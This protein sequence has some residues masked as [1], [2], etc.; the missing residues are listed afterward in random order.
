VEELTAGLEAAGV[1]S[2]LI[3]PLARYGALV[4]D[5]NRRF[6]LTGAKTAAELLPHLIDSLTVVPYLREPYV[7]IGSGAG[8][9]AIPA[10]IASRLPVTMIEATRKKV[11]FLTEALATLD[12][13]GEAFAE[14][15]EVAGQNEQFRERFTSGTAR[16]VSSAPT[17]AEL[18]LPLIAPGGIAVLQRGTIEPRE[19]VALDDACLILGAEVEEEHQLEGER[20]IIVIRKRSSTPLRFPRRTGIP[21][22][23]PLCFQ[24]LG[25][26]F[27]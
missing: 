19:R 26:E 22:K 3:D 11:T 27:S 15:A 5:A 9:P 7:D 16:A 18:L 1:A 21:E 17:V 6:N 4:L 2:H 20:R 25:R 14:R 24:P 8:L 23:R 12:L 10:A 13:R